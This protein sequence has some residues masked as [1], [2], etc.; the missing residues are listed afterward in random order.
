M[1]I[2]ESWKTYAQIVVLVIQNIT[3]I[4]VVYNNYSWV[5]GVPVAHLAVQFNNGYILIDTF[6]I[7]QVVNYQSISSSFTHVPPKQTLFSAIKSQLSYLNINTPF[8][9]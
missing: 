4:L 8:A 2:Q 6:N 7:L 9:V 5:T 3:A 1:Y